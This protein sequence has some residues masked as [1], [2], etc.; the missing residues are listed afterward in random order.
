MQNAYPL[1]SLWFAQGDS[2]FWKKKYQEKE[3]AAKKHRTK[4][5]AS[6][7]HKEKTDVSELFD[8]DDDDESEVELD[9]LGSFFMH[10]IDADLS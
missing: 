7:K 1:F 4:S 3:K 9:S 8:L 6:K 10:L 2:D 5:K